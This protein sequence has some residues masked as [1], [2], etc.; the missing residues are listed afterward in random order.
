M[1]K[2]ATIARLAA[3][4]PAGIL[5]DERAAMFARIVETP[6]TR[7]DRPRQEQQGAHGTRTVILAGALN[8]RSDRRYPAR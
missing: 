2:E 6:R 3:A 5:P 7:I 8:G 4:R 1:S